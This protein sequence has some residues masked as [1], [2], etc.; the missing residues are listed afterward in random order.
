MK[1][2]K[3]PALQ[4]RAWTYLFAHWYVILVNHLRFLCLVA[5]GLVLQEQMLRWEFECSYFIKEVYQKNIVRE[6]GNRNREGEEAKQGCT[7]RQ[8]LNLRVSHGKRCSV[9]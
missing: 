7:L 4:W 1:W 5:L 3:A 9:H 6:L 2:W 8:G